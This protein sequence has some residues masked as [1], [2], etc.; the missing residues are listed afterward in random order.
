LQKLGK[1]DD[2][3]QKAREFLAGPDRAPKTCARGSG[4]RP[5]S[6]R[7]QLY[8][9]QVP[10]SAPSASSSS[11]VWR[12]RGSFWGP[13]WASSGDPSGIVALLAGV[14]ARLGDLSGL[15]AGLPDDAAAAVRAGI[16]HIRIAAGPIASIGLLAGP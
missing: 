9:A 1:P 2:A 6:N 3:K 14:L 5:R 11:S 4:S 12:F 13:F 8:P 15:I 16:A 7:P 10:G